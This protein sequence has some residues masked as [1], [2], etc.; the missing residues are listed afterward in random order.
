MA[1]P[2]ATSATRIWTM[3]AAYLGIG[4]GVYMLELV[5]LQ[6]TPR[7]FAGPDLILLMT[8]AFALRRPEFVPPALVALVIVL[9]DLLLLRPP[10]LLHP[11]LVRLLAREGLPVSYDGKQGCYG[12]G[13]AITHD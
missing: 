5:P 1:D 13:L 3:R 11:R 10:H 4:L 6:T 12:R 9:G 7:D 8:F 2:V